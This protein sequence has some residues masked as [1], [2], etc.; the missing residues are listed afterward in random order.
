MYRV[1]ER[2]SVGSRIGLGADEAGNVEMDRIG[3]FES[4]AGALQFIAKACQ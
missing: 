1:N 3:S 2:G 4:L